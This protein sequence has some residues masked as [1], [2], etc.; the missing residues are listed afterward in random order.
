MNID[1][2]RLSSFNDKYPDNQVS[3]TEFVILN[4]LFSDT[5]SDE[6]LSEF[7]EDYSIYS[8][9]E[10][11]EL[12]KITGEGVK[13]ISLRSLG[14]ELI[15]QDSVD[16]LKDLA[17]KMRELFPPKIRS[18]GNL[19][20]SSLGDTTDKL[21]KFFKK[22][23]YTYQQV[24][25]ATEKYVKQKEYENFAYMKQLVYFIE[26]DGVSL[27]AAECDNLI[28]VQEDINILREDRL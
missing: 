18:G 8:Y 26:K 17:Q 15:Y 22:H 1:F 11:K 14:R 24:L 9:L 6:Y 4:L 10:N 28:N 12:I 2:N 21:K 16:D 19:V 27:L 13:D 3:V 23:K 25:K 7:I 20:R 5:I